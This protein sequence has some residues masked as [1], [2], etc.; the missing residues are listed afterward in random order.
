MTPTIPALGWS[1]LVGMFGGMGVILLSVIGLL[2][3]KR[4]RQQ[5]RKERPPQREKLLRPPG[6]SALSR[7]D[8][9]Q[10]KLIMALLNAIFP[11]AGNGPVPG[12]CANR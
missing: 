5:L 9:F 3:L 6:N 11:N 4:R 1:Q 7:I 10:D 2:Q 8:D 12:P